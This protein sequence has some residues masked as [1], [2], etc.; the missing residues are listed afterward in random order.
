MQAREAEVQVLR[1]S[2]TLQKSEIAELK[3]RLV[4]AEQEGRAVVALAKAS[5]HASV[6]A[7]Q[8][9]LVPSLAESCLLRCCSVTFVVPYHLLSLT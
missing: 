7:A 3:S 9:K 5:E 2:D 8:Q 6:T 4:T 1:D